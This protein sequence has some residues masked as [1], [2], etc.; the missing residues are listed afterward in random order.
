MPATELPPPL[1]AASPRYDVA[2][3]RRDFPILATAPGGKPLVY[4]DSAATAQKP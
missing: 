2:A 4:L 1:A 3:V